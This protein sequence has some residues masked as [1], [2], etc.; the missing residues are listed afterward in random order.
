VESEASEFVD[1][2]EDKNIFGNDEELSEL[3]ETLS[4]DPD[5]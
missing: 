4:G 5:Y 2:P 1:E 3:E